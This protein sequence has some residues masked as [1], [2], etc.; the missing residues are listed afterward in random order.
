MSA[1]QV[2]LAITIDT[3]QDCSRTW[4]TANPVTFTSV[5]EGIPRRLQP[6]FNKYGALPTYL[7]T[8]GVMENADCVSAF[9]RL[10]ESFELGTHL[11]GE[12]LA[13][14]RKFDRYDGTLMSDMQCFYPAQIEAAKLRSLT[15]LYQRQFGCSPTSFRA[16]RFAADSE[17]LC[18]LAESGYRI[19][20]SVT[21]HVIWDDPNGRLDFWRAYE[22]PYHPSFNDIRGHGDLAILEVPVTIEPHPLPLGKYL[23]TAGVA[24]LMVRACRFLPKALWLRPSISTDQEMISVTKRYVERYR[25]NALVV[26]NMMFHS[27]EVMPGKSPYVTSEEESSRF[28][29]RI[30]TVLK[31]CVAEGI[32][33]AR[34]LDVYELYE[35]SQGLRKRPALSR[36]VASPSVPC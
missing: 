18:S 13:P 2:V 22:Q 3:E 26:L 1:Q 16:G 8:A 29:S 10:G 27:V 28:L 17:T 30:E 20:T 7:L 15:E 11:H 21:P 25:D 9:L 33:F 4:H 6:L 32:G 5:T 23:F 36:S 12:Y 31:W 19:D 34:L 14:Q 35:S 24:P